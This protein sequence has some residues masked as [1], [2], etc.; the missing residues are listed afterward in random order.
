MLL[1]SG[2]GGCRIENIVVFSLSHPSTTTHPPTPSTVEPCS[3]CLCRWCRSCSR[4]TRCCALSRQSR[5]PG[6][7]RYAYDGWTSFIHHQMIKAAKI[8]KISAA[9]GSFSAVP[10]PDEARRRSCFSM[11][12]ALHN[13]LDTFLHV[14]SLSLSLSVLS[15]A[16]REVCLKWYFTICTNFA[17]DSCLKK[18]E[19][20]NWKILI[21]ISSRHFPDF[22]KIKL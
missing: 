1:V 6:H 11:L 8:I 18:N 5:P 16:I 4:T 12:Q 21:F 7:R 22:P 9:D 14:G 19:F 15:A 3:H 13:Y 20:L 10:R 2:I 17:A